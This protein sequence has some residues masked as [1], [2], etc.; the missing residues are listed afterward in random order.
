MNIGDRTFA[1]AAA[2]FAA[3]RDGDRRAFHELVA[4]LSPLLW[5]VARSQ[6]LDRETS[7]DVVQ[8]AWL[9]LV[10]DM[11]QIRN[12]L[13][14]AGW[15]I[16]TTKRECWRVRDRRRAEVLTAV[17]PDGADPA[18][19][20]ED[21]AGL[22][23]QKR[24]LWAAVALL[25]ERCRELLRYVAFIPR[26]DYAM[27]ADALDMKHGSVGPT[28]KRCLDKLHAELRGGGS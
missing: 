17:E 13:A 3:A 10:R 11:R 26:P 8:T 7:Q 4:V 14:L 27:I 2:L 28:R 18:P 6:G 9:S 16:T 19:G 21:L 5:H 23:D 20:P 22:D 24:R 15:L 1:G 25:D 12:P